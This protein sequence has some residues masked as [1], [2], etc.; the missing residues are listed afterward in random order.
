MCVCVCV[1]MFMQVRTQYWNNI[2]SDL[3]SRGDKF[4]IKF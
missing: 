3:L 4:V 2:A 1:F